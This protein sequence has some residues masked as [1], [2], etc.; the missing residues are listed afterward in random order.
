MEVKACWSCQIAAF[1]ARDQVSLTPFRVREVRGVDGVV[2][3]ELIVE[4]NKPQEGLDFLD[5]FRGRPL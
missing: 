4:I 5:I 1:G 3:D 2:E